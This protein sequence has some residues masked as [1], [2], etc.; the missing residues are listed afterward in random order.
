MPFCPKCKVEYRKGFK[1]CSDCK[2]EL[3]DSLDDIKEEVIINP[4]IKTDHANIG[5]TDIFGGKIIEDYVEE[6]PVSV[7][8]NMT[9]EEIEEYKKFL[10]AK[11]KEL[12]DSSDD[13]S[14]K[15]EKAKDYKSTGIMLIVMG[16]LGLFFL[17]CFF[18]NLIPFLTSN[19]TPI[20]YAIYIIL[21]LF[22]GLFIYW[23]ISSILSYKKIDS[24]S[25]KEEEYLDEFR[26]WFKENITK[27]SIDNDLN[28]T[29]DNQSNY[30]LRYNKIKKLIGDKY[31]DLISD[32]Y[33]ENY[34]DDQYEDT[35]Q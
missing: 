8:E 19:K 16:A 28:I 29:E 35:F 10:Y 32:T 1:T 5:I 27:E 30:F 12:N 17:V 33:I 18:F 14:T 34:I 6:D 24:E 3:L 2:V 31:N 9:E 7:T 21:F 23:G 11:Q 15:A 13:Y 26:K 25:A 22:F 20:S 4:T